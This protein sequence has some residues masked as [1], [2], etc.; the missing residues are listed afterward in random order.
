VTHAEFVAAYRGGRIRVELEPGAAAR[1]VSER[2]L[3]PIVALPVLGC[4][5]ALALVG[6]TWSGLAVLAAGI[7]IPR[8]IKRSAP[9]FILT[10]AIEDEGIYNEVTMAGILRVQPVA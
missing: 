9:R 1:Y 2:L 6:W 8:Q 10:Q 5:V 4:G 3:L 7:L